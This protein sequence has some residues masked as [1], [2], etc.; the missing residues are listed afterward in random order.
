MLAD[1]SFILA[2]FDNIISITAAICYGL[3]CLCYD[4]LKE[5][6]QINI[7]R[8]LSENNRFIFNHGMFQGRLDS[9]SLVVAVLN[10]VD[11]SSRHVYSTKI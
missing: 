9:V 11:I 8:D 3:M 7:H 10:G 4:W 1:L 6:C 5:V 2:T